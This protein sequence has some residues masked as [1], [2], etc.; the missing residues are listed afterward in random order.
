MTATVASANAAA[1]TPTGSVTFSDGTTTLATVP[2]EDGRATF[3]TSKFQPGA[4]QITA[5]YGGDPTFTAG[6]TA[7]PTDLTTGFSR[8]C[9]TDH[10]G[11]LT[12]AADQSLC[13]A[14][15]AVQNGPVEVR[16]GG[17]LAVSDARINGPVVSDGAPSTPSPQPSRTHR[18]RPASEPP[19][20]SAPPVRGMPDPGSA[21]TARPVQQEVQRRRYANGLPGAS[22][23]TRGGGSGPAPEC[24]EHRDHGR[25]RQALMR[26]SSQSSPS[27]GPP[28]SAAQVCWS[29][30]YTR[31]R[32]SRSSLFIRPAFQPPPTTEGRTATGPAW[33]EEAG[34]AVRRGNNPCHRPLPPRAVRG[35][36]APSE[37]PEQGAGTTEYGACS[38]R[39]RAPVVPGPVAAGS[40][41]RWS[42]VLRVAW[43]IRRAHRPLPLSASPSTFA[44]ATGRGVTFPLRP[45]R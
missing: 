44:S 11:P 20:H 1:G 41:A 13:I 17:A 18:C 25:G 33:T 28:M 26:V 4:H 40:P 12:V 30:P 42:G 6:A 35:P 15:G 3:T 31:P 7:V 2:L 19:T 22:G 34:R 27:G 32:S 10:D 9:L 29:W 24:A 43:L 45:G 39:R 38:H 21:V 16:P 37:G 23:G 36:A 5:G 8:P 14:P